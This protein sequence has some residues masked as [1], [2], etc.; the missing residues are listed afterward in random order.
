MRLPLFL[1]C[2]FCSLPTQCH[3][4]K[5]C[6]QFGTLTVNLAPL[7]R[8]PWQ[9]WPSKASGNKSC[10]FFFS[11]RE[12]WHWRQHI[13]E[14]KWCESMFQLIS[15]MNSGGSYPVSKQCGLWVVGQ[16]YRSLKRNT[17]LRNESHIWNI[18]TQ[19]TIFNWIGYFAPCFYAQ[20]WSSKQVR[21]CNAKYFNCQQ[22][23]DWLPSRQCCVV[24]NNGFVTP[25]VCIYSFWDYFDRKSLKRSVSCLTWF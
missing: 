5:Q 23:P 13:V 2:F 9:L 1:F 14:T 22:V 21:V 4:Q 10:D 15:S 19:N 18:V 3:W 11:R 24:K 25:S 12:C 20:F 7:Q 17:L 8:T 6:C 16:W